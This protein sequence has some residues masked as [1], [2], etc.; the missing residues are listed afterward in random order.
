MARNIRIQ[1]A[2]G[3]YHL[4][5]RGNRREKIYADDD[6]RRFFLKALY[7]PASCNACVTT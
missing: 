1:M 3:F 4:M 7:S 2:G 5:V 6:E